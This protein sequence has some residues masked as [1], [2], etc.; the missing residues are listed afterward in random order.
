[1]G[2]ARAASGATVGA[3][4]AFPATAAPPGWIK[5]NGATINR[6]DYPALW[7]YAQASGNLVAQGS[8]QAGNFGTGDGVS[9]F[10]VPD[11]RATFVRGLDDG[12]GVDAGRG[13]GTAQAGQ[14]PSHTHGHA[15][16]GIVVQAGGQGV[17]YWGTGSQ[18]S[19]A[20]GGTSNASE[21]RPPNVAML[22][23]IRFRR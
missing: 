12:K 11:L 15:G 16:D 7:A 5:A 10:S 6:G 8:K 1:M 17:L 14:M 9:T 13:I 18:Q 4:E 3:I 22:V 2:I 21:N 23:C 19:G 20:T